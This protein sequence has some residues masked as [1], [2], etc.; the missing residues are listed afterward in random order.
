M[1]GNCHIWTLVDFGKGDVEIRCTET[2]EHENHR[3][4]VF[5]EVEEEAP[6]EQD[7]SRQNIFERRA[8]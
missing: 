6:P 3:C 1:L 4:E 8:G 5:I 7:P 2:G